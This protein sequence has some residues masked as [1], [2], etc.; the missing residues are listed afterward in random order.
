[1]AEQRHQRLQRHPA[2]DQRGG[3]GVSKLVW[4]N[5]FQSCFGGGAGKFVAQDVHRYAAPLMSEQELDRLAGAWVWQ[6]LAG[7]AVRDDA[8]DQ[9]EGLVVD[10]HH[11]LGVELAQR[12]L[13]PGP[14]AG[15]LM[16]TVQFQV[17]QFADAHPGGAQQQ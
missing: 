11:P 13:Q 4:C 14:G 2:V 9:L 8:V 3:V 7:R 12:N 6:W 16:H 10:G 1:M 15:N 17:E 5:G